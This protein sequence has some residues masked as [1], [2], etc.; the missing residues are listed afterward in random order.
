MILALEEALKKLAMDEIA[1]LQ[2]VLS[3][4]DFFRLEYD[5][6]AFSQYAKRRSE[7]IPSEIKFA[8]PLGYVRIT[9][10]IR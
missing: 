9:R 6:G 1:P 4:K 3:E 10:E 5:L 8:G 7:G 2:I